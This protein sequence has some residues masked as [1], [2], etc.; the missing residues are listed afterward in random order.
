MALGHGVLPVRKPVSF[1]A[2]RLYKAGVLAGLRHQT[3]DLVRA[4]LRQL[5]PPSNDFAATGHAGAHWS[6][7]SCRSVNVLSDTV[8]YGCGRRRAWPRLA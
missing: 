1:D 4:A 2:Y 5:L 3:P 8:C 7:D 6:C